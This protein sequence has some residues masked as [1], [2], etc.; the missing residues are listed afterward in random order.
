MNS[1]FLMVCVEKPAEYG[2]RGQDNVQWGCWNR[3]L[4]VA[5]EMQQSNPK[6]ENLTESIWLFELPTALRAATHFLENS[7]LQHLTHSVFYLEDKP[8]RCEP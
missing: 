5:K 3:L 6:I 8:K 1:T 7:D 4:G 2:N